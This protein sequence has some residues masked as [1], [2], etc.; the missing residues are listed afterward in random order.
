MRPLLLILL[1]ALLSPIAGPTAEAAERPQDCFWTSVFDEENANLFYPD[2]GVNYYL[3]R[4]SLPPGG[5]LVIRGQYPHA[6]YTSFNVYDETFQPTD[7]LADV[8]IRPDRGATNPF[9]VGNRRDRAERGY[10]V[11]VVPD[12]APARQR[13]RARN[14]V[15]LG[16]EGQ[17]RHNASLVL[18]IYLPDRGRNQFGGVPLPEVA[19]RLPDGTEIDQPAT[20]TV[21]TQQ[22]STGVTEADQQGSGPSIP[23]YTTARKHPDWER[24]FNVPRTMLRQ[25]S[26]TLADEYGAESRGGFFSDGNNAYVS[27]FIARD[28]GPVL[29]LRGRLPNV[30]ETFDHE[31]VFT[32][33]QLRYWSMCSVSMQPYSVTDTIGCVNDS[34][35]ATNRKGWYKVVVST[36]EDRPRNARRECGVT[37]LPFGV[38]PTAALV[39]RN[40]LADPDF[41][42]AIQKVRKPG[43]EREVMGD[44]LPRG[45]YTGTRA[46]QRQGC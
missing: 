40:Q 13:N 32:R 25:F 41:A 45:H 7:A 20:C 11:K 44:F 1:A 38:R 24:F 28:F 39:M 19:V 17:P 34:R 46:V 21:L 23:N 2:T 8:D 36:P 42:H 27:A 5:R 14:T 30:P 18:R 43:T 12:P 29:V 26:Q 15:Y 10:T 6:R 3:G 4:V 16:D 22:P 33:G 31:R 9:V 35:L 37:W